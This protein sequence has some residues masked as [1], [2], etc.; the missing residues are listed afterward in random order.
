VTFRDDHRRRI[1]WVRERV[2]HPI[3]DAD[4]HLVEPFPL[5]LDE[6]RQILGHDAEIEFNRSRY[7]TLYSGL[8]TWASASSEERRWDWRVAPSWWGTPVEATDRTAAYVPELLHRR[9]E[10][11]GLDHALVYP[12]IGLG[13]PRIPEADL[14]VASCR[15]LN[16]YLARATGEYRDR[17][18]AVA[19]IPT[20]TPLEAIGE[21]EYAVSVLGLKAIMI[22]SSVDRVVPAFAHV[23]EEL[24]TRVCRWD[25]YGIDSEYDYDPF[26]DRCR[27]LGVAVTAHG[28]SRGTTLFQSVSNFSYNHME[29][30]A[31][32]GQALAKSLVLG[33][34]T[35]RFP[36]L[37]FACLEGGA[38]W[39]VT[40]L[41]SLVEHWEV[42]GR[43]GLERVDPHRIDVA[44]VTAELGR[45]RDPAWKDPAVQASVTVGDRRAPADRDDFAACGVHSSSQVRQLFAPR[46]WFGCEAD[47]P[48][49]AWALKAPYRL[50]AMFGSDIGHFDVPDM[51]SV[52][53]AAW[54]L[55]EQGLI[56]DDEFRDYVFG[57]AVRL[58]GGMNPSF[59]EGTTVEEAARQLLGT[60]P[61]PDTSADQGPR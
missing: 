54:S 16:S 19:V 8:A 22:D 47:D 5:F 10:Q 55:R 24:G 23:Y 25:T 57:N 39:G 21:L 4:A 26:W 58:H 61:T 30:F 20:S 27:Q 7:H 6:L 29:H 14:R 42:R 56:D 35:K 37:N 51:T 31:A 45:V 12:S 46:F 2:D 41:H 17:L 9:V 40:L 43:P 34:V 28:G 13:L 38:A 36:D 3:V 44:E 49:A 1:A 32:A 18:T 60:A 48:G 52:L 59:F 11:L 50:N 33:G 53:P 15:A